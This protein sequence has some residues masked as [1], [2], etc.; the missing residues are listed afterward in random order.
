MR[1]VGV[2]LAGGRA[3][4]FDGAPKGLARVDGA[5]LIDRVAEALRGAAD[6]LLLVANDP[7]AEGWLPGVPVARDVI[8]DAGSL[9]GIHA[10]LHHAAPHAALVVA[11]DMPFVTGA[12]LRALR[13]CAEGGGVDAVVPRHSAAA[14]FTVEPLCAWYGPGCLTSAD[15]LLAAGQRR[16]GALAASVRAAWLDPAA[17]GDPVR[18]FA[19]VNTPAEL[20]ALNRAARGGGG[21]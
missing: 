11:W 6:E 3:R 15:R 4:R 8:A 18:L 19:N 10:A 21:A 2:V 5:R 17:Y 16:A 12:L 14:P 20:A 7:A 1:T 13:E 9:G